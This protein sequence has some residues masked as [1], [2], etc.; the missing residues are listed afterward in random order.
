M[1]AY[2]IIEAEL[3]DPVQFAEYTRAL[4][5]VVTQFGGQY[6]VAGGT[7]VPLEGDWG[8]KRI[9]VSVWPSMEAAKEFW[10]SDEYQALIPLREGTGEFRVMLLEALPRH[11]RGESE[12]C[13]CPDE[14]EA[15][16]QGTEDAQP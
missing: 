6:R 9:V 4:P 13:P 3:S 11:M 1:D 10:Y 2:M 8:D 5:P 14:D 7:H 16:E 12:L 15:G